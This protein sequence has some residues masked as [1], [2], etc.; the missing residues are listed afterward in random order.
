ME[1]K[2]LYKNITNNGILK[3]KNNEEIIDNWINN[4]EDHRMGLALLIRPSKE[5]QENIFKIENKIREIEPKQYFYLKEQY[6]ITLL[7]LITARQDYLYSEE[8]IKIY[9]K[10]IQNAVNN[11]KKFKIYFKG[12]VISDGAI[13]VKGYYEKEMKK[14]RENLRQGIEDNN[15]KNDER[16]KTIS[17]HIT[18]ARFKEKIQ[19]REKLIRFVKR[20]EDYYFGELE[21]SNI[22]FLYHNWYDSK[23]QLMQNYS[24]A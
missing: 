16:Y 15:L 24:I 13:M 4:S 23:K 5:I 2:K 12:L 10:I 17:A 14:I 19:N 3:I 6:H 18:I 20:Y 7:D 1:V 8:E 9:N 21:V 22:E 11:A